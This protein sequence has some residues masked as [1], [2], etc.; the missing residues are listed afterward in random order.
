MVPT[1]PTVISDS[2]ECWPEI[3]FANWKETYATLH[4]WTQIVGKV[5]LELTPKVN[6]WWN[7]PLYV[8]SRGLTTS[9]I[10]YGTRHFEIEFDFV[11]QKLVIRA[12]DSKIASL[13]LAPRSVADFYQEFMAALRSLNI[14]VRIWKLPVEVADPIPFD[15][16]KV[17]AAYDGQYVQR[18][19]RILLSVDSVFKV[20][21]SRF[22]GKSSPVHFFW[23][24]FDL[25][26]TRFSGRRAPDRNDPDPVLRKIMREA[27]SH[28]VISAG[29]WPG[30][31]EVKEAAFYCYAAPS[32]EGFEK[33]KVAPAE[34]S[35]ESSLGEY[36]LM[37]DDVRRA[38]SPSSALLQF[39]QSTYEAG[40]MTGKW[41]RDALE[42][43]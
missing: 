9:L 21:R 3:R 39:L 26:V 24:S 41:D 17:H 38:K 37:Y 32:P 40:A 5:R 31:G 34:A 29:W 16:D 43:H 27:Y 25:A 1:H 8:S 36:L 23:G 28:E 20:F 35:Y 14:E 22:V 13:A 33:Q 11:D 42:Q 10:P 7:V 18:V 30:S 15:E 6:H 19:W 4:M 12:S 2:S